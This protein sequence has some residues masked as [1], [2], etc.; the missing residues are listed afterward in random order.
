MPQNQGSFVWYDLMTSDQ[1][2][3]EAFYK[4]VV[5]WDMADSGMPDRSYTILSKGKDQI[6]GLM[7]IPK[8]ACDRGAKPMWTGYIGVAD[9]DAAVNE[10][11]KKGGTVKRPPE[12][13]PGVGRFSVV[14][15]PGGATFNLF[16][17]KGDE[18]P[19]GPSMAP[20]QVGWRELNAA[21]GPKAYDFYSQ[22]FGWT[23]TEAMDMGNLGVYQL[24]AA[25]GKDAV[26][27]IMTKMA[28]MPSPMWLFYF[29]VG[30]ID[31]AVER[32]KKA[33][34]QVINGPMEVPGGAWIIQ[35]IDPQGAMFAL[36]GDRK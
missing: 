17:H 7:P 15:D 22:M 36:V 20:G 23:K 25:G 29:V 2:A 12:D 4:A 35:G 33:G 10:L 6:G 9:V 27:G 14:A 30:N 32:V 5:G 34:G 24:F 1:K 18:T 8:E 19:K 11:K 16:T 13:I 31:A 21:D 26:G 3:A 28:E